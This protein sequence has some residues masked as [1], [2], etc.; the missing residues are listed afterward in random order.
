MHRF[1]IALGALVI[2]A[3]ACDG[4]DSNPDSNE[5]ETESTRTYEDLSFLEKS[6][7]DGATAGGGT[8]TAGICMLDVF[9]DAGIDTSELADPA[10]VEPSPG[11]FQL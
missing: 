4:S 6:F 2:F 11:D 7:V 1:T 9:E 5:S 3:A 8:E 10:N